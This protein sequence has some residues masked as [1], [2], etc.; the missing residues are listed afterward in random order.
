MDV[1]RDALGPEFENLTEED[2]EDIDIA[3]ENM[4][5]NVK[6][7]LGHA[8]S[9]KKE[10]DSFDKRVSTFKDSIQKEVKVVNGRIYLAQF[11]PLL[12]VAGKYYLD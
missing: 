11:T 10:S 1:L 2:K 7:L 12:G 8:E 9:A 5:S 4:S 3:L 6:K